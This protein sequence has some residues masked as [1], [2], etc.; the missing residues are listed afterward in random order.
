M[1]HTILM[2]ECNLCCCLLW[3]LV[4]TDSLQN[5]QNAFGVKNAFRLFFG[6]KTKPALDYSHKWGWLASWLA[7]T[8]LHQTTMAE[9]APSSVSTLSV[10][11]ISFIMRRSVGG[12][13]VGIKVSA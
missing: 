6:D 5:A 3:K 11:S 13:V 9:L 8:A 10:V 12:D 7:G 2:N 1:L 4:S